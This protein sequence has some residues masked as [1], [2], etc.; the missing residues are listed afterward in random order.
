MYQSRNWN[1]LRR[2]KSPF[3]MALANRQ[4]ESLELNVALQKKL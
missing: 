3:L 4:E 2:N 1:P